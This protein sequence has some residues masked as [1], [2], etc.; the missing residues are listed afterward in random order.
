MVS[1]TKSYS[2]RIVNPDQQLTDESE[3][4]EVLGVRSIATASID[5]RRQCLIRRVGAYSH[6]GRLNVMFEVGQK[7]RNAV[8]GG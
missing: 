6:I 1:E 5:K 8:R 7:R 2:Q 3:G 4:V